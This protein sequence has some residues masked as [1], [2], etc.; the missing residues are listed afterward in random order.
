[1]VEDLLWADA[2]KGVLMQDFIQ[3]VHELSVVSEAVALVLAQLL[4]QA[5]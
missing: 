4:G 1:M 3:Q 5:L 2:L